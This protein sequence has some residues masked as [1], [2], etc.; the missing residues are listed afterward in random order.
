MNLPRKSFLPCLV[1]KKG[2][3]WFLSALWMCVAEG[4]V[5]VLL[6]KGFL[7]SKPTGLKIERDDLWNVRRSVSA[8]EL[9]TLVPMKK[10]TSGV[11]SFI[12]F[13]YRWSQMSTFSLHL[14]RNTP[15][16]T[17]SH[18]LI[19]KSP[20]Q[21]TPIKMAHKNHQKG[22]VLSLLVAYQIQASLLLLWQQ[23]AETLE[24]F[25]SGR[26]PMQNVPQ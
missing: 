8:G 10:V 16:N 9:L 13:S 22:E 21:R 26:V 1:S 4:R 20:K 17:K 25:E 5:L 2:W 11:T 18:R 14:I 6:Q 15:D 23:N 19:Q 24:E 7:S 12:N 3:V